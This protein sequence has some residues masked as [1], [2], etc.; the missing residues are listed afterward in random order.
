MKT[1]LAFAACCLVVSARGQ[2]DQSIRPVGYPQ[3]PCLSP[4]GSTIVFSYAGDLWAVGAGGGVSRRITSH[5]SD[6][7]RSAFS[8]DGSVLAFESEREGARAVYA[9]PVAR[10]ES[11]LN[12]GDVRRVTSADRAQTLSGISA[13][14]KWVYL[15]DNH[16]PAVF[17]GV[18]M[19]RARIDGSGPLERLTTAY[20]SSAHATPDGAGVVFTRNRYDPNRPHYAGSATTDLWRLELKTGDFTQLSAHSLNEAEGYLLPDGSLVFVSSRDGQNNIWRAAKGAKDD[21]AKPLT[22][23]KPGAGEATIAHGVRDFSVAPGGAAGVFVV[24]DRL[25]TIDLS[26]AKPQATP[27]DVRVGGDFSQIDFQKLNLSR[28]VQEAALSPDGKTIALAA[29]G[30][31]F[32]RS[33]DKERPTRRVTNSHSRERDLAWSPDGKTLYFS[34]DETGVYGIYAA[35]VDVAREDLESKK[36]DEPKAADEEPKK[37]DADAARPAENKDERA[38]ENKDEPK[39]EK[40]P[41]FG[42][43][44]SE[45]LTFKIEP[46]LVGAENHRSARPSPDGKSVLVTRARGDLLLMDVPARTAR[47]LFTG[48]TE[49][50]VEWC[51][52]SR[53]IV[54]AV[55][56]VYFN[57]DIWLLDTRTDG[58]APANITRH[59]DDDVSPRLS[60]DGKVLYFLSD[61]DDDTTG[62]F[63][64]YAVNLDRK[65]DGLSAYELADYFK[66]AAES[67]KKRKPLGAEEKKKADTKD[68]KEEEQKNGKNGEAKDEPKKE[69][70]KK[71]DEKKPEPLKF[72]L[73]DAYLRVRS[74]VSIPE[75][76]GDLAAAPGGDRVVFSAS[77]DGTRG[78][79]SV[80]FKGKE[81]KAIASAGVSS[82]G[83]GLTGEKV[84]YVS[85][86]EATIGKPAGGEAEKMAID[87]PVVIEI[88]QQQKQKF[89]E[90]ARLLGEGF[91]HPTLK[92]LDWA[93]LTKRYLPLAMQTRTDAEFNTVGMCLFGELNGSHLGI[94]GGRDS[95]GEQTPLG[96][97]G[98]DAEPAA[99]G[100]RVARVLPQ[101]PADRESSKLSEGDV[102]VSINGEPCARGG[103]PGADLP[104]QL[105]NTPGRETLLKV[106]NAAGEERLVLITPSGMGAD[107]GLRYDDEVRRRT[108]MVDKFSGGK[109]GY[110]HIRSMDMGS[111]RNFERDLYAAAHGRAGLLIDVR[112]NG[113]GSTADILLSSLTAPRHAYTV[114]RGADGAS[115]PKDAYPR[116]RRLIYGYNR[117]ISVLINQNS[118][119]NAEI[120]PHAIK[121]IGRGK[122]VG[123][124]TFGAVISTGAAG[125]IDGTTVRMPFRGWYLPN[126]TDMEN[127]GAQP[128]IE[129]LVKPEDEVSGAD[130]QIEAAVKELM[131]RAE[132]E[133]F[134]DGGRP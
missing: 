8:P 22:A 13:D 69:E 89:L 14:G 32:V 77:V 67:A 102:I 4:D 42:K 83:M 35:T 12:F 82:V 34:S 29:R 20:G 15:S 76:M 50:E 96:Y 36:K 10:S 123:V 47:V 72:D 51:P 43:R 99:E 113:G 114:A 5:P 121:T 54:Y 107:T 63:S 39:D 53:H 128:D 23:F 56:D 117:P 119:S 88:A 71:P 80:D 106:K 2:V 17:R 27:V 74:V 78:L 33:T 25:Y 59:P 11:G 73:D 109:I 127:H 66:E 84:A 104:V 62:E 65:L 131:E 48:W 75:G 7:S 87:A 26:R 126:G 108:A 30:E 45:A 93:A 70:S 98:I 129:V 61:R 118:Y 130:P 16:E 24:W 3:F 105:A 44:W 38:E 100:W 95:A 92:G 28:Q 94:R 52:D 6:E 81:R 37:A 9:M 46:V 120:F 58:A 101:G 40:K 103:A 111:V 112:D 31:I 110:L 97:V 41:D 90:A 19:Y 64:V 68:G 60:A 134:W 79:Y 133:P 1:L 125:L 132:K 18:K 21:T 49:P 122:L 57:S 124:Q 116:D 55:S 91:Y 85:A 115:I 86:G